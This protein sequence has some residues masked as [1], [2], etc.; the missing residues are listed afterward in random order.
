MKTYVET[1]SGSV[2]V[3]DNVKMTWYRE[4]ETD[5]SGPLRTDG[6][7]LSSFPA[8]KLDEPMLLLGPPIREWA[9]GRVIAT[10]PVVKITHESTGFAQGL[11][12]PWVNQE[13]E[14]A[15]RAVTS[16]GQMAGMAAGG[17]RAADQSG[18]KPD[19]AD[20][21][22]AAAYKLCVLFISP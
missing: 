8:I 5:D 21:A 12:I 20:E 4:T 3:L 15:E 2:Y 7:D 19:T 10:T 14:A 18:W 1:R 16:Y 11:N 17:K 22:K 9:V 13:P 6:G